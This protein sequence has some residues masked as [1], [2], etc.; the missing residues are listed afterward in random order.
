VNSSRAVLITGCSSG[1]GAATARRLHGKG[2]PVYASAR[3][4][5]T[6]AEL[7]AAGIRTLQ[8][9]V[10]DEAS[11]QAAVK[12]INDEQ[13]AVGI[14]INNAG[15]GV[16]G[17]VEEVPLDTMRAQFETNLFGAARLI[18]LVLPGMRDQGW[19]RIINI[20]SIFGKVGLP[21]SAHYDASKHAL[22]GFSDALRLEV[23]RFGV[24]TVLIQPGPVRSRF[25]DNLVTELIGDD[26]AYREFRSNL[27]QWF[28]SLFD[29]DRPNLPGRLANT[30]D[31]VAA[32]IERAVRARRPRARYPVGMIARGMLMLRRTLPDAVFDG[33]A[34]AQFP[35]P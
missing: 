31:D 6:L 8:L 16:I 34:R 13:G 11:T 28:A 17:T 4:V 33:M 3:R 20:S 27:T 19:G 2:Y 22:E 24:R 21:G 25:G 10:T 5:E 32:V 1:I 15:F 12:R 18:Q 9:D 26:P 14:L 30:P 7:A 35:V 23:A 29:Q